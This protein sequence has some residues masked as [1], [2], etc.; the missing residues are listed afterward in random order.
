[1]QDSHPI[2]FNNDK[3]SI[4]YLIYST[5]TKQCYIRETQNFKTRIQT[6]I[7]NAKKAYYT[8]SKN[9]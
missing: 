3:D 2:N 6:E 9:K 4:V 7:R 5:K 8:D 1:M